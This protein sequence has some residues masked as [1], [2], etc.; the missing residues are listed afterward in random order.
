MRL[1]QLPAASQ[2]LVRLFQSINFG[3]IAQLEVR[4]SLPIFCPA[5]RVLVEVRLDAPS[6]T[7]PETD[8]GDFELRGEV[9]RLLEQIDQLKDGTINR[10]DIRHGIPR[11]A[12]IDVPV[13]EVG[14]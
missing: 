14:R 7:R 1:S 8:L 11:R 4:E 9:V 12:V 10:I 6:E 2:A 5:P 13:R 3:S